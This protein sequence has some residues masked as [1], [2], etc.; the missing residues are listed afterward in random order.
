M[1]TTPPDM[2]T[3]APLET[4]RP[5]DATNPLV[6]PTDK[7]AWSGLPQQHRE[8]L[9]TS[10]MPQAITAAR[11]LPET[12]KTGY[13]NAKSILANLPQTVMPYME[14]TMRGA[15]TA[16]EAPFQS[17]LNKLS[18]RG[19]LSSQVASD[20]MANLG[21]GLNQQ[22]WGDLANMGYQTQMAS[23]TGL[24]GLETG[25]A[26]AMAKEPG[27][28]AN[29]IGLGRASEQPFQPYQAFLNMIQTMM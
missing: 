1:A 11:A 29:L 9:L 19:M 2:T 23:Q 25:E 5:T 14:R 4:Q 12:I 6:I 20:A 21:T 27:T 7:Y 18:G 16:T 17:L 10:L 28:L 13:G 8:S 22:M 26:E 24:A 15:K 3:P